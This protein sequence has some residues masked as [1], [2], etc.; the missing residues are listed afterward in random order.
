[1]KRGKEMNR[2]KDMLNHMPAGYL[3]AISF[4]FV[5]SDELIICKG[6]QLICNSS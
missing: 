5:I 6:V 4:F 3:H 2:D 1:M